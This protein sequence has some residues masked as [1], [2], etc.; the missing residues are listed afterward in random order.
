MKG[1]FMNFLD[2]LDYSILPNNHGIQPESTFTQF[3]IPNEQLIIYR[4][5]NSNEDPIAAIKL[6]RIEECA[7]N[8]YAVDKVHVDPFYQTN[9]YG[10]Y[11]YENTIREIGNPII[12]DANLTR[13]GSFNL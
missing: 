12:C 11:L 4:L 13:P 3:Y 6:V 10:T 7:T 5:L 2:D 1:G 9:G 8:Y